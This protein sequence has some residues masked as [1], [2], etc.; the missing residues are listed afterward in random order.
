MFSPETNSKNGKKLPS[1]KEENIDH[2]TNNFSS[3]S[4]HP[5]SAAAL[6]RGKKMSIFSKYQ[7]LYSNK[8]RERFYYI[9][10][11]RHDNH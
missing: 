3:L 10:K 8:N 9:D 11:L 2:K 4:T 5:I 7:A 1:N 6:R